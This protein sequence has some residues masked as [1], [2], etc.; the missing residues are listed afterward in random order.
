[1]F[2]STHSKMT[3]TLTEGRG[4]VVLK[5]II[6]SESG[7]SMAEYALI[8]ALIAVA[9]MTILGTLGENIAAKFES[10]SNELA[11]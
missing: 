4:Q 8:A 1:M 5:K 11:K 2:N 10:I 9:A 6:G 3:N 7:Q